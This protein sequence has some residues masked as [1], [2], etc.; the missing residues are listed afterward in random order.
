[1][2]LLYAGNSEYELARQEYA[3]AITIQQQLVR[4]DK[5]DRVFVS[6]LAETQA[7]LGFLLDQMG[8]ST[9]AERSLRDAIQVM[10]PLAASHPGEVEYIHNLA[11]AC[12][13]LSYVLRGANAKA[14]ERA[15]EDAISILE[16]SAKRIGNRNVH[17]DDLALCYNNLAALKSQAGRWPE[18]IASH[19]H[20]IEVQEQMVRR[21]PSVV[22]YRS[23]L[24]VSLNNLG[25]AYCRAADPENADAAFS[26]ARELFAELSTDYPD[27]LSYQSS[28]AALLN[29]QALALADT[30]RHGEAVAIYREAIAAQESCR[31]RAPDSATMRELLSKMYYNIGQ[32]LSAERRWNEAADAALSRRKLW[33]GNGERLLGV[34]VELAE[35][36]QNARQHMTE[37]NSAVAQRVENE[38][39][40]TM[41][42]AFDCGWS[43]VVDVT[44]EA[45][46]APLQQN[47]RFA[48]K[49]AE[50]NE[51][52]MGKG[53]RQ[54]AAA[55]SGKSN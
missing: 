27:L 6:Q 52:S 18:A 37:Y 48:A 43:H 21:S 33:S 15:S 34:A 2:G 24:A 54:S 40:A 13:N 35:I 25:V 1:L 4:N 7:N 38:V 41:Q 46:F 17:Q 45:R 30:G 3:S 44:A 8:D 42:Q 55:S 36:D 53:I 28:L 39:V 22:R 11:I 16:E 10:R 31:D 19:Q 12:N 20:A 51:R 5:G 29:N 47:E 26:R 9:G 23:D 32:S 49:V 50:L 14:A